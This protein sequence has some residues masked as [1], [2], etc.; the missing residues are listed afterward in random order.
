MPSLAL[1]RRT[2]RPTSSGR[3]TRAGRVRTIVPEVGTYYATNASGTWTAHRITRKV[4]DTSLQVDESTGR[5][6]VLVTGGT[7]SGITRRRRAAAGPRP[8]WSDKQWPSSPLLRL[9]PATGKLL[10]V[11]LISSDTGS[12]RIYALTGTDG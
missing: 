7:G 10:A 6:H 5:S 9:D 2:D 12:T 8:G 4:G 1:D 3:G 11:Y